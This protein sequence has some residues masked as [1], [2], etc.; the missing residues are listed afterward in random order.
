LLWTP[1]LQMIRCCKSR[2]SSDAGGRRSKVGAL[3]QL[4][5]QGLAGAGLCLLALLLWEGRTRVAQRYTPPG[6]EPRSEGKWS[7]GRQIRQINH[8]SAYGG[9]NRVVRVLLVAGIFVSL[10]IAVVGLI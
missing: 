5:G 6:P 10:V 7:Y 1:C 2:P 8:L 4:T 9:F 3:P